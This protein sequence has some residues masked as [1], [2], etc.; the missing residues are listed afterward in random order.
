MN[1]KLGILI[2]LKYSNKK[3]IYLIKDTNTLHV[4]NFM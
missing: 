4:N 3:E 2:N 1:F